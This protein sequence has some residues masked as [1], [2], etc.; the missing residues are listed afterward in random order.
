MKNLSAVKMV[1][2][3]FTLIELMIVVAIVGILAAIALP[4]YQNYM[5]KSKL[6]EVTGFL[7]AQK[8][9]IAETWATNGSFPATGSAPISTT[10]PA[11][12]KYISAVN[13]TANG[14][15]GPVSVVVTL[16]SA[17]AL[18]SVIAGKFVGLV[19]SG[20]VTDG[21]VNWTCATFVGNTNTAA[22]AQVAL[23]PYLPAACQN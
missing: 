15:T 17:S 13:Y 21:T 12:A 8:S 23:Y 16:G 19:G 6:V 1:Q 20:N 3:G 7:D 14:P 9:A 18:N 10:P 22:G 2:K 4:A 11:N 5:I